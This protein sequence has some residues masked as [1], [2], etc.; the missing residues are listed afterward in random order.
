MPNVDA[1]MIRRA[2]VITLVVGVICTVIGGVVA[3]STGAL[4][5]VL[6]TVLVIVFFSAGQAVVG[7]TIK[8]NPQMALTVALTVYLVKIGILFVLLIVLQ[9]ATWFNTKVFAITIV[10]C[11]I[12]WTVAEVWV[13]SGTNVLYVEPERK[14]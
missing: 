11:T 8:N 1:L 12:S 3:G 6:G 5:G 10:A 2:G 7:R 14:P 4:G 9:D 13:Y